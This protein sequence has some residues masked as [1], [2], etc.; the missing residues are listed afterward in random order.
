MRTLKKTVA[1][2]VPLL[3]L[4]CAGSAT[5]PDA[6]GAQAA[7]PAPAPAEAAPVAPVE[8][9][10]A[11]CV[12]PRQAEV[13]ALFDRWND[14]LKTGDPNKVVANYAA[15][16]V[17]LPTLSN[18]PRSNHAEMR[19][20]FVHFLAKRPSGTIDR[21]WIRTGC[22]VAQDVGLYTFRFGDNTEV[23][24][25]YSYFYALIG[26]RWLITHHHS[27]AMPEK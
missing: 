27:S 25:R 26:G 1:V 9:S 22:N 5:R 14:S 19:E 7:P 21:R 13:I 10:A 24:A 17:L 2:L 11:N 4:G 6:A 12:V 20:Y 18:Q 15:D 16:G 3:L 23:K 8:T